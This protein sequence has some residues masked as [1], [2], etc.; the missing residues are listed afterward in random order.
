MLQY[1]NLFITMKDT[2]NVTEA[3]QFYHNKLRTHSPLGYLSP[4]QYVNK[5]K[6]TL[7]CSR[8]EHSVI[9]KFS[10]S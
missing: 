1:K 3:W 8:P 7:L 4:R 9:S 6:K 10:N 2:K 5:T